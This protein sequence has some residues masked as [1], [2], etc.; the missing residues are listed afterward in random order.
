MGTWEL[1]MLT[2]D[3]CNVASYLFMCKLIAY[4]GTPLSQ[5]AL[6]NA[7]WNSS[8]SVRFL[9]ISCPRLLVWC[10]T[11]NA[12]LFSSQH[13]SFILGFNL[14][15]KKTQSLLGNKFRKFE[16]NFRFVKYHSPCK[17]Y[18]PFRFFKYHLSMN[19]FLMPHEQVVN[20]QFLLLLCLIV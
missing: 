15:G 11:I 10:L 14:Q 3:V 7:P 19:H 16:F 17:F 5:F 4:P 8:G 18:L 13:L 9:S 1:I 12:A 20:T 2:S 6:K